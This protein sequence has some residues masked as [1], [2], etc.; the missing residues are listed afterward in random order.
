LLG[1]LVSDIQHGKVDRAVKAGIASGARLACG[2]GRPKDR[3]RGHFFEP[4]VLLD[5]PVDSSAWTEEIFGPVLSVRTF[6]TEDQALTLAND[7]RFGLAAAVMSAD[8]ERCERVAREFDAGI[9]WINCSQ[10][11]FTQAPW[12]GTKQSGL[13]RELGEWGFMNYLETKQITTYRARDSWGWY[14]KP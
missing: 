6:E 7:T 12:G 14:I 8:A 3:P 1:P 5:P 13:G 10:P 11:T 9:V 2:G 4:T